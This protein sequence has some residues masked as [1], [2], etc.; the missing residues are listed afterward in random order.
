[1]MNDQSVCGM[2][3]ADLGTMGRA[4][5]ACRFLGSLNWQAADWSHPL[6]PTVPWMGHRLPLCGHRDGMGSVGVFPSGRWRTRARGQGLLS[7]TPC[8]YTQ[9]RPMNPSSH[10]PTSPPSTSSLL[11]PSA[12]SCPPLDRPPP[13]PGDATH[14]PIWNRTPPVT[15]VTPDLRGN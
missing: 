1:M 5:F 3:R 4:L 6:L 11:H 15:M 9:L 7:V 10:H 13:C 12:Y 14:S 8:N 2:F